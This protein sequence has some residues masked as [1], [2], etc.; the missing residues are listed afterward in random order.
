M[1]VTYKCGHYGAKCFSSTRFGNVHITA[2]PG[3]GGGGGSLPWEAVSH[4]RE[5]EKTREKGMF[6]KGGRGTRKGCQLSNH[7]NLEK[8]GI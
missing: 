2:P 6:F 1:I 4:P 7:D 8:K 3:G 5:E